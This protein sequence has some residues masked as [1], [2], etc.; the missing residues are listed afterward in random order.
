MTHKYQQIRGLFIWSY[1]RNKSLIILCSIVQLFMTMAL[2]YGYSLI[3]EP[4]TLEAQLYLAAG[5]VTL[6]MIA[7]GCTIAAQTISSAKQDGLVTYMKTLPVNRSF[8]FFSE[9]LIWAMVSF[10]GVILSLATVFVKFQ[11][12]PQLSLSSLGIIWLILLTM[13]SLG[14]AIAYST[15]PSAMSL[16]TQLLLMLGLLFSPIMFPAAR[17][18]SFLLRLYSFLPFVPAG[19]LMRLS[20]Y[21]DSPVAI[22]DVFILLCWLLFTGSLSVWQLHRKE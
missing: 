1:V 12:L 19:N 14:F 15:S 13:L 16:I 7:I 9:L 18:P 21:Q 8:I 17:I 20:V 10:F 11:F 22:R 3:V 5:S 6:G 2:V 4:K